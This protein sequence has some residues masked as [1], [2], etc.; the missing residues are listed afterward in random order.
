[1]VFVFCQ[2][3]PIV[4][5]AYE[6]I[7]CP[8]EKMRKSMCDT[9]PTIENIIDLSHLLLAINSSVNFVFYVKYEETFKQAFFQVI[10]YIWINN[11]IQVEY[12]PM[13]VKL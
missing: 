2:S 6:V 10:H 3:F 8:Y 1:M 13:E 9:N 11:F 4:A 7:T 12:Y 5:D